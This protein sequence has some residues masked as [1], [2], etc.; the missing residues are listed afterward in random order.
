MP[1]NIKNIKKPEYPYLIK[2]VIFSQEANS[3]SED[4]SDAEEL[5]VTFDNA[6]GG[7]FY[8][9]DTRQFAF[10]CDGKEHKNL[11]NFANRV[12]NSNDAIDDINFRIHNQHNV[13]ENDEDSSE[14]KEIS[15]ISEKEEID[16]DVDDLNDL[17]D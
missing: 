3:C 4:D 13:S 16:R 17:N 11:I 5:E 6:G 15:E 12:C 8:I 9:L 1:K 10:D 2:T 14:D 7:W